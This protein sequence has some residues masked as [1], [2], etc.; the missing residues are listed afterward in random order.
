MDN[1][2]QTQTLTLQTE[3]EQLKVNDEVPL[4]KNLEAAPLIVGVAIGLTLNKSGG[5]TGKICKWVSP[6]RCHK[7]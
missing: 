6:H 3:I 7:R 5:M 1:D 2:L 4:A